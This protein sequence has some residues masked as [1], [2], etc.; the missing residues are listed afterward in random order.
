MCLFFQIIGADSLSAG[1]TPRIE[2][3]LE[4][5]PGSSDSGI[6]STSG[7]HVNVGQQMH[8]Q[9]RE[10][11]TVMNLKNPHTRGQTG[12]GAVL[13]SSQTDLSQLSYSIKSDQPSPQGYVD[14]YNTTWPRGYTAG[15]TIHTADGGT[16]ASEAFP[17]G[18]Y[19]GEILLGTFRPPTPAHQENTHFYEGN[20]AGYEMEHSY[21]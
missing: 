16:W 19:Q 18:M 12:I 1:A 2:A 5:R 10:H 8:G 11:Q 9:Y 13:L 3:P 15:Q 20:P 14:G 17:E 7:I 4:P 21:H 6:R